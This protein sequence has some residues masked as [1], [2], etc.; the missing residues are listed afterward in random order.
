[1]PTGKGKCLEKGLKEKILEA[2]K[3][4]KDTDSIWTDKS[5][6][7][8][9]SHRSTCR[10]CKVSCGLQDYFNVSKSVETAVRKGLC[11]DTRD[12]SFDPVVKYLVEKKASIHNSIDIYTR[13]VKEGGKGF[14]NRQLKSRIVEKF[15]GDM[16]TLSSPELHQYSNSNQVLPKN[17][18]WDLMIQMISVR[19]L[20]K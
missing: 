19:Q 15:G 1:M 8:R 7:G 9:D 14:P 12:S 16:I 5:E 18:T 13:Y 3:K 10:R 2:C 4:R 20:R 17:S 6:N 11:I